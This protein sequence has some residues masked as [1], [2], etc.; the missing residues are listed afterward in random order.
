MMAIELIVI[1]TS[2]GG[3]EALSLILA[4]LPEQLGAAVAICQHRASDNDSRL[5]ELL[6]SR[7]RLPLTEPDDKDSIEPGRAYLA[8]PDYHLLVEPGRF[9]LSTE[10]RALWARP[11]ID[12]LFDSAAH[13]YRER[14]ACVVL[15]G[16]SDDGAAGAAAIRRRGGLV[17]VQDPARATSPVAPAAAL[18]RTRADQ[19]LDLPDIPGALIRLCAGARHAT[20]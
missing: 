10:G 20:R 2:L 14:A 18:A 11:S 15:T 5:S 19:V 7:S 4:A 13:A 3:L 16:A 17:I 9:A 6:A 8:P 1:G 12:V